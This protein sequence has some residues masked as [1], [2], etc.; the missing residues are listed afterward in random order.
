[1]EVGSREKLE[2]VFFK[3][4]MFAFRV[5]GAMVIPPRLYYSGVF[6]TRG[7]VPLTHW[8]MGQMRAMI[9]SSDFAETKW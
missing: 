2:T 1:M 9:I 4:A 6:K 5:W 7:E 3:E 8:H